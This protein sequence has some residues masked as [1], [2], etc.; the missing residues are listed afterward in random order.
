MKLRDIAICGCGPAGLAAALFL[1]RL[2]HRVTLFERFAEPKPLGSGLLLQP[3]GQAVLD[4]LGL[5]AEIRA[6]GRTVHRLYG[7][8]TRSGRVVLDVPYAPLGAGVH[9]I[10][11]HRAAL[12]GVLYR[13][14]QAERLP[15]ETG[16]EIAGIDRARGGLPLLQLSNSSPRGPFDLVVDALGSRSAIAE[17]LF[18]PRLHAPLAW[19]ALWA[20]LPWPTA[21]FDPLTLEQ[22]YAR[23]NRMIGV[24]PIGRRVMDGPE[25]AAFFWSLK[26]AD[27]SR[28]QAAGLEPWKDEV[29]VLWPETA[30][31]L[32][33]ITNPSQLVFASYGHHTLALPVADR[34]AILG[35]AAHATSPQL[36]QGANMAL[37][38]AAA[39]AAAMASTD[40]LPTALADYARTR[41][42]HVR[43][44]Q[45][46]GAVLTPFYQ[47]DSAALPMLRDRAFAIISKA[48]WGSRAGLIGC[49]PL[50]CLR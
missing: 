30:P 4:A 8:E 37:L 47:S 39:L 16:V 50:A 29:R 22:R 13:A 44:Y 24:L 40:D 17:S 36:G 26:A 6:L 35:D 42:W 14:V 34:I 27:L 2:G 3:G 18:G 10:G 12:F 31:L 20:T 48:R 9:A 32:A 21:G 38:D 19:G 41:R 45:T 11:V 5:G 1:H 15:I 46:L 7:K 33:A 23:A 49:R 28:W 25:E 43:L